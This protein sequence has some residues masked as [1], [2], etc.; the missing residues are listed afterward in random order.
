MAN[1][2]ALPTTDKKITE[3]ADSIWVCPEFKVS[4]VFSSHMVLQRDKDITVWGFSDTPGSKINGSFMGEEANARVGDDCK[5][6]LKFCARP[7]CKEPQVMEIK[8]DRGHTAKFDD[9]DEE[10]YKYGVNAQ[11]YSSLANPT[12]RF[13]NAIIYCHQITNIMLLI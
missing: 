7:Y 9:I 3:K 6:V 11:F 12:T 10:L 1:N 5:W 4:G 13:V 8:D 2:M